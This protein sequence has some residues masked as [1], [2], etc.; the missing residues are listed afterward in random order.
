MT[1]LYIAVCLCLESDVQLRLF[2]WHDGILGT[3]TA[4]CKQYSMLTEFENC[5]MS[6]SKP[7]QNANPYLIWYIGCTVHMVRIQ[8]LQSLRDNLL[9]MARVGPKRAV[10]YNY[11]YHAGKLHAC[12]CNRVAM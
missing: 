12:A 7:L 6:K 11:V 8:D 9:P 2:I 1:A 4:R 5:R 10:S 3:V